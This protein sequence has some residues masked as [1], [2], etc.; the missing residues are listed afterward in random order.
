MLL[1]FCFSVFPGNLNFVIANS[2]NLRLHTGWKV[3]W[4]TMA[5][6]AK[7]THRFPFLTYTGPEV[8]LACFVALLLALHL[9]DPLL[10]SMVYTLQRDCSVQPQWVL[11][12]SSSPEY[13][14]L[15]LLFASLA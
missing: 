4:R 10:P 8:T 11:G 6:L 14:A 5:H 12:S 7:T 13:F 1:I 15:F 2:T 3:H 9:L